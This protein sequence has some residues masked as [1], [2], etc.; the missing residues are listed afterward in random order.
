IFI[1]RSARTF[2]KSTSLYAI[3]IALQQLGIPDSNK[4]FSCFVGQKKSIPNNF[5]C[6]LGK[7]GLVRLEPT[8]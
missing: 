7:T 6:F 3:T 5:I 8:T 2:I 4:D 1:S